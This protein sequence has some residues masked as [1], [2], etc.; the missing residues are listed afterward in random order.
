MQARALK[1][2]GRDVNLGLYIGI[3][4][5]RENIIYSDYLQLKSHNNI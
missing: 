5:K 2:G 4:N 3:Y 1:L